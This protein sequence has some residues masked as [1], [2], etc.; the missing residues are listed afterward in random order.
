MVLAPM[1]ESHGHVNDV[2]QAQVHGGGLRHLLRRSLVRW[3]A[4]THDGLEYQ[5]LDVQNSPSSLIAPLSATADEKLDELDEV[6]RDP[7]IWCHYLTLRRRLDLDGTDACANCILN[8]R[9]WS[10]RLKD[11]LEGCE[12]RSLV[13]R[14][15]TDGNTERSVEK[16]GGRMNRRVSNGAYLMSAELSSTGSEREVDERGV[17][18]AGPPA[19]SDATCCSA[20]GAD[21]KR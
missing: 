8:T 4:H 19:K 18:E 5:P 17:I 11:M 15:G 20:G 13:T 14:D 9:P 2:H 21:A 6:K 3:R 7:M 16:V 12:A 1:T 10:S